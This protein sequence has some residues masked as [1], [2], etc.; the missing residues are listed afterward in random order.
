MR[1]PKYG[2]NLFELIQQTGIEEVIYYGYTMKG[3][4]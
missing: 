3:L 1:L 4:L 2:Y